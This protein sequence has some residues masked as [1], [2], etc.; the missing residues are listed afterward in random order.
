VK[1]EVRERLEKFYQENKEE[2]SQAIR[3]RRLPQEF[4][5]VV[6]DIVDEEIKQFD[7]TDFLFTTRR[8][9]P[10]DEVYISL[11]GKVSV[12]YASSTSDVMRQV[13]SERKWRVPRFA[14]KGSY[15]YS[16]IELRNGFLPAVEDMV[17]EITNQL[18]V[19]IQKAIVATIKASLTGSYLINTNSTN[20][21]TDLNT[22]ITNVQDNTLTGQ[23]YIIGR[24]Q[25]L[26]RV[27]QL[28]ASEALKEERDKYGIVGRYH[29]ADL[30]PVPKVGRG[31][32]ALLDTNELIV[33]A[34]DWG[35]FVYY[36]DVEQDEIQ[37]R[38]FEVDLELLQEVGLSVIA[39]LGRA[40]RI[41]L[42]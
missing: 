17:D 41:V 2:I 20:F 3:E 6:V 27:A 25:M 40:Y 22:A 36:G 16:K 12:Y 4:H 35:K 8:V 39:D 33:C 18:K 30:K 14:V 24:R 15:K 29:D 23:C 5:A 28:G 19:E 21:E 38:H 7:F 1:A 42:S 37:T 31:Q 26:L 9:N 32:E 11:P 13:W 10:E 34:P